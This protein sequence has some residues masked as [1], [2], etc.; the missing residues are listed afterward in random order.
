MPL[1]DN[2]RK[3][4]E[5]LYM[6]MYNALSVYA[7]SALHDHILAEEVVQDT[8][9]IACSKVNDFLSSPNPKGWLLNTLKYVISNMMR[10][11]A[12]LNKAVISSLALIDNIASDDEN[13]LDIDILYSD[14]A[15]SDDYKLI[16][17]IALDHCS[18]LEIAQ[19]LGISVE[20]CKKLVQRARK[21]LKKYL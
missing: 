14:I 17:M 18:M 15:N 9:R 11:R 2:Q 6:E 10:S 12:H 7:R 4:V 3:E 8:F 21:K 19:E 5:K 1:D 16:K 20:A 13:T